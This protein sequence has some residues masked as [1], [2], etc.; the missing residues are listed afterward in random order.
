MEHLLYE[1]NRHGFAF[2]RDFVLK[3]CLTLLGHGARYEVQKFRAPGVRE[4][5]ESKWDEI[6]KSISDV[7][8]F[9]RGKTF[10]KCDKALPSYLV[11]IPLIY[12]RYRHPQ[13][14]AM[15]E[16]RDSYLLRSSLTGAFSG[17]PG[18]VDRR[19]RKGNRARRRVQS[20]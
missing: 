18:S 11:L 7:L 15:A 9:V 4:E 6:A 3:T 13:S 1:L 19:S 20:Q 14:W 10:I 5:I 16:G 2:T 12:V 8:D 17:T